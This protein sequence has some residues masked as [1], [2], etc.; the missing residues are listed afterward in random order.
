[1]RSQFIKVRIFRRPQLQRLR[2]E[3]NFGFTNSGVKL[4]G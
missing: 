1:L 3:L 2:L 4:G